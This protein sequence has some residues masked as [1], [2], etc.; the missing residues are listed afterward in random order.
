VAWAH[1]AQVVVKV[2]WLKPL[3]GHPASFIISVSNEHAVKRRL[4]AEAGSPRG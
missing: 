4:F 3:N 1:P 2:L